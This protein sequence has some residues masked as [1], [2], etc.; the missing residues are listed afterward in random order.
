MEAAPQQDKT[1]KLTGET[2]I[3]GEE[4]DLVPAIDRLQ[5]DF[6]KGTGLPLSGSSK[7]EKNVIRF[8]K[9]PKDFAALGDEAYKISIKPDQVLVEVNTD[10]GVFYAGRTLAQL[11]PVAFF[12]KNKGNT[13]WTLPLVEI[14]DY[15]RFSWRAYTL[16]E[17]RYFFGEKEVKKLLDQMALMKM[18]V[19]H[20]HLTNDSG[21]RL[22][23]KKYPRLTEIGSKRSDSEIGTWGS[24]KTSG[25]PH[26]GFYTQEQ[27]KD[28]VKYA[29]ERNI[30]IIPEIGMPGHCSAIVAAYPEYGTVK[31][32]IEMPVKFGKLPSALDASDEKVYQFLSDVLDEVIPLFPDKVIHI[33]GDEVRFQQWEKSDAI[34]KLVAEK[35]LK[36]A[37][38]DVQVYFTNKMSR[39]IQDKGR[40]MM[41]WNEI[42]GHDLHG[43]NVAASSQTLAPGTIIH[44]WKGSADLAKKAIEKGHDVVN[45]THSSTYLDYSY[46]SISLKKAYDFEPIFAGLDPQYHNK[47]LGLGCQMWTEWVSNIEKLEYQTFPRI[48]AYAEVAWTPKE[49]KDFASFKN[50][51]QTH[52]K[53]LDAAGVGYARN[54]TEEITEADFFNAAK[55]GKWAPDSLSSPTVQWDL[56]PVLKEAGSYKI[57]F[58]YTKGKHALS[59]GS[60]SVLINGKEIATDAHKGH[61]GKQKKNITYTLDIPAVAPEDKVILQANVKGSGGTDSA[62]TVYVE[63]K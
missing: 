25:K 3:L 47:V 21:W 17:A 63:K 14:T 53:R 26:E 2:A 55:L 43:Q 12:E 20:W 46:G 4:K 31:E 54:I 10:K 16:D 51:L 29:A 39:I 32:P 45:S 9:A 44:F 1:F 38:T 36:N 22:E 48:C 62:G 40:R 8:A 59:I 41:G 52:E 50:R 58:L 27:I 7:T 42:L 19:L 23:I 15:P 57:S 49:K 35:G 61:S 56:R 33:G 13:E 18:N 11:L 30:R 34:K 60:V 5:E 24:G 37:N 28:I 6:R